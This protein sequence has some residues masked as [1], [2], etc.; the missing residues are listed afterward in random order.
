LLMLQGWVVID[1][2]QR[3]IRRRQTIWQMPLVVLPVTRLVAGV[4]D[5]GI[6]APSVILWRGVVYRLHAPDHRGIPSEQAAV[7]CR[8]RARRG[9]PRVVAGSSGA[10]ACR[11]ARQENA[12]NDLH[13]F[14][15]I[16][17]I[18]GANPAPRI[19]RTDPSPLRRRRDLDF[20]AVDPAAYALTCESLVG[21]VSSR[22]VSSVR[23]R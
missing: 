12:M 23:S 8:A 3:A 16:E 17:D 15:R 9:P 18:R 4:P 10:G 21:H 5:R 1:G 7:R 2:S 6:G 13:D 19:P 11:G 20:G 14:H 22:S